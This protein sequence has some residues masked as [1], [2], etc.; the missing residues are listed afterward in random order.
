MSNKPRVELEPDAPSGGITARILEPGEQS[1][2]PSMKIISLSDGTFDLTD[3]VA[4]LVEFP[5]PLQCPRR[6]E[7]GI[8]A[9]P[10]PPGPA[11]AGRPIRSNLGPLQVPRVS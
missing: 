1:G 5:R 9:R 10:R 2:P 6:A 8:A 3:A 11:A 4:E 7:G